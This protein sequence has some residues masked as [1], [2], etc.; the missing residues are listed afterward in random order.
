MAKSS[1]TLAERTSPDRYIQT[2]AEA[3][4]Q[5]DADTLIKRT[6]NA[7]TPIRMKS[8]GTVNGNGCAQRGIKKIRMF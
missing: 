6:F 8:G 1:R 3:D 4:K 7:D 2:D 5:F